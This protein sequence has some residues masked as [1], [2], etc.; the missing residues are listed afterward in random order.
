V[1]VN[2]S[3]NNPDHAAMAWDT[4]A[5]SHPVLVVALDARM[6]VR[7]ASP[8][9]QARIPDIVDRPIAN[10]IHPDDLGDITTLVATLGEVADQ[11]VS[12]GISGMGDGLIQTRLLS[13]TGV[14]H[15]EARGAWNRDN[16]SL[17][18][19]VHIRDITRSQRAVD[20]LGHI[21]NGARLAEV[22]PAIGGSIVDNSSIGG[23]AFFSYGITPH[24]ELLWTSSVEPTPTMFPMENAGLAA[25]IAEVASTGMT[26]APVEPTWFD[27]DS[28]WAWAWAMKDNS[29]PL[30]AI[31]IWGVDSNVIP[32]VADYWVSLPRRLGELALVRHRDSWDLYRHTTTDDLTGLMSRQAFLGRLSASVTQSPALL[33]IDLGDFK[34]VTDEHGHAVGETLLKLAGMRISA[35][36][37]AGDIVARLGGDR[38]SILAADMSEDEAEALAERLLSSLGQPFSVGDIAVT[39]K[40]SIGMSVP[41][42]DSELRGN[43]SP[44]LAQADQAL[45]SARAAGAGQYIVVR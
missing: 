34:A 19:V 16:G 17:H 29:R 27:G 9:M 3:D 15:V 23:S 26:S 2:E 45:S 8:A 13:P 36:V 35:M 22:L 44:L 28:V 7:W 20:V 37:R 10:L 42:A 11:L 40:T 24:A 18:L 41:A 33:A 21:S 6:V 12:D 1:G 30:G 32:A 39:V 5:S 43:D 4:L 31:I 25:R 38:F 14:M